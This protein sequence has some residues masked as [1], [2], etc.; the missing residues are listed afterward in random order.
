MVTSDKVDNIGSVLFGKARRSVLS[1]LYGHPDDRYYLRQIVR[2]TGIG[3]GPAQR[4]LKTLNE[5]GI[6][7]RLKEG[8]LVYYQANRNSPV[9]PELR[10]IVRKT[11][12]LTDIIRESLSPLSKAIRIA[13]IFGSVARGAEGKASDIDLMVIGEV[14]FGDV[15]TAISS[16]EKVIQREINP[17]VYPVSEFQKKIKTGHHFLKSVLEGEKIYLIGNEDELTRLA[18]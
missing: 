7:L 9:F 4:E 17:V 16:A 18:E 3:L 1:L 12:G 8:P 13:F 6:I 15:S 2:M 14:S 5:T 11:F 10:N